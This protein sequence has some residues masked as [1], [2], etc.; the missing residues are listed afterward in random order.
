MV[1]SGILQINEMVMI[2]C[3]ASSGLV[4]DGKTM[5]VSLPLNHTF[6]V[7]L[8]GREPRWL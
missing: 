2:G 8:M 4:R 3:T 5:K 1:S 6:D 7:Y